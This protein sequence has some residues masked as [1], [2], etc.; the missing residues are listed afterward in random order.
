MIDFSLLTSI[1]LLTFA[2]VVYTAAAPTKTDLV[3]G[4]ILQQLANKNSRLMKFIV[5]ET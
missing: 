5:P 4:D 2:H 3:I 1:L